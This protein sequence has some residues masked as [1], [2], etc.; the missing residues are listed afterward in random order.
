[1]DNFDFKILKHSGI[2]HSGELTFHNGKKLETPVCWFGLSIVEPLEFQLDVFKKSKIEAFLS[3]AYDLYYQD[4]KNVRQNLINELTHLDLRHKMDSGGFQLMKAKMKGK[5]EKFPLTPKMVLDKQLEI[6]CDVGVQLDFPFG[7]GLDAREKKNRINETLENLEKSIKLIDQY[8]IDFSVLP[9]I[10]TVS[11]DLNLLTYCLEKV[12]EII[13]EKPNKIGIGSLVPL[14]KTIKGSRKYRIENFIYT[15]I[16]LRKM[17]PEAFIHAFGVG[18]TMAYLAILAGV[19]SYDSN[20]WIQKTAYG[21]IQLPGISDRFLKKKD[22]NRTYLIRNRKQRNSNRIIDEIDIFMNCKCQACKQFNHW[23]EK[24]K[25]FIGRDQEPK[26]LRA[27]HNV[28]LYQ[29][30]LNEMRRAIKL[31]NLDNFIRVRLNN[32]IYYKYIK[33]SSQLRTRNLDELCNFKEL[34]DLH[35]HKITDYT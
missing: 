27:I 1:M 4:K 21:V 25:A 22:H 29:N 20:G 3:N 15:L 9:V 26:L 35:N 10:H 16:C 23:K 18:G 24:Q 5:D 28:S 2:N 31:D 11:D 34:L 17:L 32:S 14:V 19:D 30:E 8:G 12:E 6:G 13:G 33:F 7:P